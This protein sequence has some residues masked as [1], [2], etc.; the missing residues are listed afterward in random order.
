MGLAWPPGLPS[1]WLNVEA[2]TCSG[3]FSLSLWWWRLVTCS[4][5]LV[6]SKAS[7]KGRACAHG[8]RL[9]LFSFLFFSSF[10][11]GSSSIT[12][13]EALDGSTSGPFFPTVQA[14][15]QTITP[16][17]DTIEPNQGDTCYMNNG[18]GTYSDGD[19]Q[20][21]TLTCS[22]PSG[23]PVGE[24]GSSLTPNS[25]GVLPNTFCDPSDYCDTESFAGS[26]SGTTTT[27]GT[28]TNGQACIPSAPTSSTSS[29][30]SSCPSG[31]S[32]ADSSGC[33]CSNSSGSF[34]PSNSASTNPSCNGG[35]STAPTLS[36][37]SPVTSNGTTSCPSG[38]DSIS[39]G[40]TIS[41]FVTVVPPAVNQSSSGTFP[42][43]GGGSGG[44]GSS[45]HTVA[46]VT[47]SNGQLTCPPGDSSI[48][49][50]NGSDLTCIAAGP[51]SGGSGTSPTASG[52]SG[53]APTSS[54]QSYPTSI[55]M[56]SLP[57][58][59]V[60]S[61]ALSQI[62]GASESTT[63][64]CPAPVTF[65]VMSHTFSISFSY[66]CTLAAKVRP[67]VIGGFSLASLVLLV[68]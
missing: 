1:S 15:C 19:A 42:S 16:S 28:M 26:G 68:R 55:S 52:S 22:V 17:Y 3:S 50:A 67:I 4:R 65:T 40:S 66:A 12:A 23:V 46:P 59:S 11:F 57:G 14:Y 29:S 8:A 21:Y 41:C 62:P 2:L 9:L 27:S 43:G 5:D 61:V 7:R 63:E 31:Y 64:Q 60:Q 51:G 10:S 39:S 37:V 25:S 48:S 36:P 18:G 13:Y 35:S 38:T 44:G 6:L 58:D 53:T 33:I 56:P 54:G 30:N 34:V 45:F 47:S 20:S 24:I 49:G 32:L